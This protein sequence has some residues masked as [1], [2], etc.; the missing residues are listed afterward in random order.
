MLWLLLQNSNFSMSSH[1]GS[2]VR[3][4]TSI[5]EEAVSIL[6]PTQWVKDPAL[7]CRSQTQ[8]R[9]DIAMAVV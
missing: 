8:L 1:C 3:N 4:P 9:S 2:V 5:H 6:G 7:L